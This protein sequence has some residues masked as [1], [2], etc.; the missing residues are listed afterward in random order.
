MSDFFN[1]FFLKKRKKKNID[2][3]KILLNINNFKKKTEKNKNKTT[4]RSSKANTTRTQHAF[5]EFR[6][7]INRFGLHK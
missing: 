5:Y 3:V 2:I 6:L 1:F 4:I 7:S